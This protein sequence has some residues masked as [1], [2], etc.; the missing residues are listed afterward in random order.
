M[1]K[2]T[3]TFAL[4]GEVALEEFATAI[5]K[6]NSLLGQLAKER[7]KDAKV[8]W[9][10]DEL[11]GG[12]AVATFRGVNGDMSDIEN[13]VDAY[14][15]VGESLQSGR[16]VPF[17]TAVQRYAHDLVGVL[18]GRVT[19]IRFETPAKDFVII[20]KPLEG[21]QAP[22]IKYAWS[23][24]RGTVQTLSMRKKLNFTLWDSLFDK[25]VSCYFKGGQED[26]MRNAWGKRAV[27]SGKVGRRVETQRP[28]VIRD[29]KQVRLLIDVEPGSY[30][31]AK[32]VFPWTADSE[33][34]EDMIGRL[35][36]A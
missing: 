1:A 21:E 24:V 29:I 9:I 22:Q 6:L 17:S 4:D 36:S 28:V 11:Y 7:A 33:L 19:S 14:E 8:V 13:I 20:S 26:I 2:D 31:R 12:S 5:D 3:L 30:R 15:E 25:P 34:P 27:V 18:N 10:I 35:R 16:E 32:G 23:S